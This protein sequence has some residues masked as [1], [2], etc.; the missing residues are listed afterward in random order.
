MFYLETEKKKK[1]KKS[2]A[3]FSEAEAWF[4]IFSEPVKFLY[5]CGGDSN[6]TVFC[7]GLG[8]GIVQRAEQLEK[9]VLL[10]ALKCFSPFPKTTF[11]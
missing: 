2:L 9:L 4:A 1:E 6:L 5:A 7:L 10:A 8:L 11:M 3:S